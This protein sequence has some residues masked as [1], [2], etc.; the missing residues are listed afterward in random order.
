MFLKI[1]ALN[2]LIK[3]IMQLCDKFL[4]IDLEMFFVIVFQDE[5]T[6]YVV[7]LAGVRIFSPLKRIQTG[8]QVVIHLSFH[9]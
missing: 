6:V 1:E 8:T 9:K 4:V 3:S 2:L 7:L 5:V